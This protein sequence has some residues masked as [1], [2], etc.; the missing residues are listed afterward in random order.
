METCNGSLSQKTYSPRDTDA[1][2]CSYKVGGCSSIV[3]ENEISIFDARNY[4]NE[5]SNMDAEKVKYNINSRVSVS[6]V[7]NVNLEHNSERFDHLSAVPNR[8]SSAS[9]SVDGRNY[10]ARSFHAAT[11]TAS[12]EASWNSQIGLLSNP[13]CA[14]SVSMRNAHGDQRKTRVAGCSIRW[15]F[16][17]KCPCSC[18]GK[19]A[20]Q[21][22]EKATQ[23]KAPPP[24]PPAPKPLSHSHCYTSTSTSRG[25]MNL[26]SSQDNI[27]VTSKREWSIHA[28][29]FT[30]PILNQSSSSSSLKLPPRHSLD[31]FRP[32][33]FTLATSPKSSM[34]D[35][36]EEVASDASSDLFEIDSFST[37][38]NQQLRRVSEDSV[39]SFNTTQLSAEAKPCCL[40]YTTNS[41]HSR[42][43]STSIART[44]TETEWYEPSEASSIDW[45]VTTAEGIDRPS[46]SD[47]DHDTLMIRLEKTKRRSSNS[48]NMNGLSLNNC[49]CEKAVSVGPNP[50]KMGDSSWEEGPPPSP[51]PSRHVSRIRRPPLANKPPLPTSQSIQLSLPFATYRHT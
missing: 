47:H 49:G 7:V 17:R 35:D 36:D 31:V 40:L 22:Q 29:N 11:P 39:S 14:I 41:R 19:K 33:G 3:E 28:A 50:V 30:F 12:S 51:S 48:N 5:S 26:N 43:I 23:P 2:L 38:T 37:T 34:I 1:S 21:V 13:A 46:T 27:R 24:P 10:M 42:L 8:F 9:S 45:S 20:V 32:S 44:E 16:S 18:S 6:P 25:G 15:L 4:F